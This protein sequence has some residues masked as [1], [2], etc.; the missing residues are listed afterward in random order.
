M[1]ISGCVPRRTGWARWD[2]VLRRGTVP[3]RRW[4]PPGA[5]REV[6]DRAEGSCPEEHGDSGRLVTRGRP[7]P[8]HG[9]EPQV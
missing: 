4:T 1:D 9:S 6:V 7:A 5:Q 8:R 3:T 2:R